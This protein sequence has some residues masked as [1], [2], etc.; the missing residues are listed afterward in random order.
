LFG[1]GC[2]EEEEEEDP[3]RQTEWKRAKRKIR[4]TK[5]G[6][7]FTMR[8]ALRGH[9]VHALCKVMKQWSLWRA[10]D[11]ANETMMAAKEE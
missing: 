3:S 5:N 6:I 2:R 8:K 9:C 7:F 1:F 4:K 10:V 11:E